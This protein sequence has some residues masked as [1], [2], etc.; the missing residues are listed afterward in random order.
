MVAP[1]RTPWRGAVASPASSR[2]SY[3]SSRA[4]GGG[5][6][7]VR[8]PC[9]RWRFARAPAHVCHRIARAGTDA[10]AG[11]RAGDTDGILGRS[12]AADR[13]SGDRGASPHRGRTAAGAGARSAGRVRSRA[14]GAGRRAVGWL[15]LAGAYTQGAD[16]LTSAE[17][18]YLRHV[19][20]KAEWPR[21]TTFDEYLASVRAAIPDAR[22]GVLTSKYQGAWQLAIRVP[23]G[24]LAWPRWLRLDSGRLSGRVRALGDRFSAGER[25]AGLQSPRRSDLRWL[26]R[27]R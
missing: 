23:F 10:R 12:R 26:R 6:A 4:A 27:P 24:Q 18:H 8:R 11:R 7:T 17:V 22:N 16:R 25:T 1:R 15:V 3:R 19:V 5:G 20:A 13:G 2:E 9:R 21:G 14:D